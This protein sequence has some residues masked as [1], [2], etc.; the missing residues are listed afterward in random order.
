[1]LGDAALVELLVAGAVDVLLAVAVPIAPAPVDDPPVLEPVDEPEVP[2]E[3]VAERPP[4][5]VDGLNDMV[6]GMDDDDA[7]PALA[8]LAE[9]VAMLSIVAPR[10]AEPAEAAPVELPVPA[11]VETDTVGALVSVAPEVTVADELPLLVNV[12]PDVTADDCAIPGGLAVEAGA[13]GRPGTPLPT[14]PC[15]PLPGVGPPVG[16]LA[17]GLTVCAAAGCATPSNTIA[18]I[19]KSTF[20]SRQRRTGAPVPSRWLRRC[21]SAT[22]AARRTRT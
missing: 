6:G 16:S 3:L 12:W 2:D 18:T 19:A 1:M 9:L 13:V 4:P 10:P 20:M 22:V 21:A 7:P 17:P 11:G 15:P 5:P 14:C 8:P